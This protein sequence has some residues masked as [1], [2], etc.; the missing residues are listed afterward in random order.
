VNC[1]IQLIALGWRFAGCVGDQGLTVM[2]WK[3]GPAQ[4][5]EVIVTDARYGLERPLAGLP[6]R[7]INSWVCCGER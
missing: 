2:S 1:V 6:H 5:T 3:L 4:L 7:S